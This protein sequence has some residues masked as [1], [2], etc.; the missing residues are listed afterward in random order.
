MTF[1]TP[2]LVQKKR[3]EIPVRLS[4]GIVVQGKIARRIKG[5]SAGDA[6]AYCTLTRRDRKTLRRS[7]LGSWTWFAVSHALNAG[8]PLRGQ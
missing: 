7:T 6:L 5:K 3:P 8:R 1:W 2:E 4:L